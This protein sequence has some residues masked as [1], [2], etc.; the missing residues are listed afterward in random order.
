LFVFGDI[1]T[2]NWGALGL[3]Y[4]GLVL[5]GATGLGEFSHTDDLSR[6]LT[7]GDDLEDLARAAREMDNLD[8]AYDALRYADNF[9]EAYDAFRYA[10]NVDEAYDALRYSDN[11][12]EVYDASHYADNMDDL[13]GGMNSID[14]IDNPSSFAWYSD[15]SF[16]PDTSVATENGEQPIGDLGIGDYILAYDEKTGSTGY[17]P[18]EAVLEHND[19]VTERVVVDGEEV[20]TTP[21]HPFYTA[22]GGWTD[23]KDLEPGDHLRKADGSYGVVGT[24]TFE[25]SPRRMYN[26][27]VGTVHTFF[28]GEGQW[29]V[30]N[31]CLP[32]VVR[33]SIEDSPTPPLSGNRKTAISRAWVEEKTLVQYTG[34]GSQPWTRK[35]I[36][37]LLHQG[38]VSGYTGHHINNVASSLD[39][40]GDPRNIIFLRNGRE[41]G[42]NEHLYSFIGHNGNWKNSSGLLIDRMKTLSNRLRWRY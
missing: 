19:A 33:Y 28:V 23:A 29:L 35:E 42:R 37:Q 3:D 30:H 31:T 10:D 17:Y 4:A 21:E 25:D 16:T 39:W 26:L 24:V 15:C 9:D 36:Q 6:A 5:P 38:E 22:E 2:G 8:E 1:A 13:R 34:L 11:F 27:T 41:G 12:D 20:V 14:N 7:H 18:I 40:Q 32:D